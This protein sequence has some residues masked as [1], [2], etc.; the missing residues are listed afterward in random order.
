MKIFVKCA[1]EIFQYP[2]EGHV[3]EISFRIQ[4]SYRCGNPAQPSPFVSI[5]ITMFRY[6]KIETEV[7]KYVSIDFDLGKCTLLSKKD[8]TNANCST[9]LSIRN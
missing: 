5:L 1:L 7:L 2:T 9:F 3:I 8:R 6:F 4:N